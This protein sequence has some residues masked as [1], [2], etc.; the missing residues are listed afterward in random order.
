M[1]GIK[2][3]F[4]HVYL[5]G[6]RIRA[7]DRVRLVLTDSTQARALLKLL[8]E[9]SPYRRRLPRRTREETP[10]VNYATELARVLAAKDVR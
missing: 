7:L 8:F 3:V 6:A 4:L 9:S 5:R 10:V 2:I 1:E